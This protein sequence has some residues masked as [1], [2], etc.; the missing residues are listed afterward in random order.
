M[1]KRNI[2]KY[3][4]KWKNSKYRKPLIIRGARQVGKTTAVKYFG[5]KYYENYIYIN[6]DDLLYRS[7]FQDEMSLEDFIQTLKLEFNQELIP[8]KTLLFIDEIQETPHLISLLRYF[9]EKRSDIHVIAAGSLLESRLKEKKITIPVGRI[10]YVFMHPLTFTEFLIAIKQE[11]LA[12]YISNIKIGDTI[13]NPMHQKLLE[14]F[15]IYSIVGGMPEAVNKYQIEQ[16][17]ENIGQ[18]YTRL[19]NTYVQDLYKYSRKSQFQT[20]S[21]ILNTLHDFGGRTIKYTN[22]AGNSYRNNDIIQGFGKLSDVMLLT[23]VRATTSIE[24]PLTAKGKMAKK[25]LTLDHG[26]I[27]AQKDINLELLKS[28][29]I[30]G[31]FKGSFAEQIVG[32]SLI[33]NNLE[34]PA[35]LYYWTRSKNTG[36]AEVDFCFSQNNTIYGIE[37]KAGSPGKLKSLFSFASN[38]ENTRL[39]RIYKDEFKEEEKVHNNKEYTL[40]NLPF[41]L[42]DRIKEF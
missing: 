10:T 4:Q 14:L 36:A 6:M 31:L 34:S 8:N 37:V 19:Q 16:T 41:Y 42:I 26:F 28:K 35:P 1:F 18:I 38:I 32:E 7:K 40:L 29:S 21:H 27:S 30:N 5:T 3:L 20:I 23:L 11:D 12:E 9:H 15:Y 17:T 39:I 24:L 22:F 2:H 25:L 33:R 13:S